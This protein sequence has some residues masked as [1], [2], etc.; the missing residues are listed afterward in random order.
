MSGHV[1]S[2][3]GKAF[4]SAS[5]WPAGCERGADAVKNGWRPYVW[6]RNE[7]RALRFGEAAVA[8]EMASSLPFTKLIGADVRRAN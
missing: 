2:L 5:D 7:D 1:V 8:E 6:T 4:L 3:Y